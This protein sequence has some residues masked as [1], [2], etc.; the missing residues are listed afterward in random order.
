M[1]IVFPVHGEREQ[2][3]FPH[4]SGKLQTCAVAI[5]RI[6]AVAAFLIFQ[7][8]KGIVHHQRI[9]KGVAIQAAFQCKAIAQMRGA[10]IVITFFIILRPLPIT[11]FLAA[12][13]GIRRV[14]FFAVLI[15][16]GQDI[17]IIAA[18]RESQFHDAAFIIG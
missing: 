11:R 17:L 9:F 3:V 8:G 18:W 14:I 16:V 4:I 6:M 10:L 15:N 2:V 5:V 7:I 1:N 13:S 12:G